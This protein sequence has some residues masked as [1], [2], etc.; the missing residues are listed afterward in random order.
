M[1]NNDDCVAVMAQRGWSGCAWPE[2][3]FQ[4]PRRSGPGRTDH[5][6]TYPLL[7]CAAACCRLSFA[8]PAQ[9]LPHI[10]FIHVAG[11]HTVPAPSNLAQETIF[12]L[13]NTSAAIPSLLSCS[14]APHNTPPG[15]A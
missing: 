14:Y 15:A 9:P 11:N 2:P 10:S 12:E 7:V 1:K 13:I 8:R 5:D 3:G 4:L 6:V